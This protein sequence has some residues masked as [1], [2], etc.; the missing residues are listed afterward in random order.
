VDLPDGRKRCEQS[1]EG[2][3]DGWSVEHK[4]SVDGMMARFSAVFFDN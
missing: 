2:G 4:I 1:E 3:R